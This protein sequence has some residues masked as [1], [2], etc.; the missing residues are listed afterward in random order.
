M[1]NVRLHKYLIYGN[2]SVG[3]TLVKSTLPPP[4]L[5]TRKHK[6]SISGGAAGGK[7]RKEESENTATLNL[8]CAFARSYFI[9]YFTIKRVISSFGIITFALSSEP[10]PGKQDGEPSRHQCQKAEWLSQPVGGGGENISGSIFLAGGGEGSGAKGRTDSHAARERRKGREGGTSSFL[11]VARSRSPRRA[12][13]GR[14]GRRPIAE[15]GKEG[16]KESR[17]KEGGSAADGGHDDEAVG[18]GRSI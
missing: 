15:T 14:A 4:I 11:D 9:L 13:G 5:A 3:I 16:R 17:E 7:E 6:L 2:P 10:N 18:N 1:S 8:Q 12:D